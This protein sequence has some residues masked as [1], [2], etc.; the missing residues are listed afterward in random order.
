MEAASSVA[1]SRATADR[2]RLLRWTKLSS[3]ITAWRGCDR[4]RLVLGAAAVAKLASPFCWPGAVPLD[5]PAR[6]TSPRRG[7]V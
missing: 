1:T 3:A 6:S 7:H 5:P 4:L 2:T